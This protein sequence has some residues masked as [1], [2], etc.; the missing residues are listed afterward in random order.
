[1]NEAQ[2]KSVERLRALAEEQR[3][4]GYAIERFHTDHVKSEW[5]DFVSV[6]VWFKK[7]FALKTAQFFIGPNGGI[8]F[9]MHRRKDGSQYERRFNGDIMETVRA[10]YRDAETRSRFFEHS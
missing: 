10:Q 4:D 9:P 3:P 5:C 7:F 1:M 2:K 6:S 8:T